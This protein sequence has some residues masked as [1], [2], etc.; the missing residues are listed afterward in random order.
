MNPFKIDSLKVLLCA[1]TFFFFNTVSAQTNFNSNGIHF[2]LLKNKNDATISAGYLFGL[3]VS[4]LSFQSAYNIRN[5]LGVMVNFWNADKTTKNYDYKYKT[6]RQLEFGIGTAQHTEKLSMSF[7]GGYGFGKISTNR[8]QV[9]EYNVQ[10]SRFFVQGAIIRIYDIV[11]FGTSL[12]INYMNFKN[13]DINVNYTHF[14]YVRA[15]ENQNPSIQ[16]E[17]GGI[18]G[19][20]SDNIFGDFTFTYF[21]RPVNDLKFSRIVA[22]FAIGFYINKKGLDKIKKPK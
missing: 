6:N 2:P 10:F 14:S 11:Y 4:G 18:L 22:R 5:N 20:K 3:N 17:I 19:F 16:P 21:H 8:L 15:L 7:Y 1:L 13:G 12:R 9:N